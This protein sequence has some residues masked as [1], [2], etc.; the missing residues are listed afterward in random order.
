MKQINS[1]LGPREKA[2]PCTEESQ[3]DPW[4]DLVSLMTSG[5]SHGL[6]GTQFAH[7]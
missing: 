5:K 2:G 7:Q 6:F 3:P 1:F 4:S